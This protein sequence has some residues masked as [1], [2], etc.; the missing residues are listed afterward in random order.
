MGFGHPVYI[1]G[2]LSANHGGSKDNALAVVDAVA[3][4]GA[5]AVKF[6][7]YRPESMTVDVTNATTLVDGGPWSGRTL[8]DLYA[9]GM[10]PWEWIPDLAERAHS[11]GI[12]WL[13]TPFDPSAV[14]F[15]AEQGAPA[16]KI[17]S[18]ELTDLELIAC[19]AGV[20]VPLIISTGMATV[21]E[22]DAAVR[23]ATDTERGDLILL[24]CNSA[25][26]A[27]IAE[28]DL[29]TIRDMEE[30]WRVPI[31]LSDHSRGSTAAVVSVGLGACLIEKHVTLSRDNPTP[32]AAFSLEPEEFRQYVAAVRE[33]QSALGE[34]RYGPSPAERSSLSFRRSVVAVRTMS[35][36]QVIGPEDVAVLRPGHGLSPEHLPEV[37]GSIATTEIP[38]GAPVTRTMIR[39]PDS[40]R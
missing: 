19:A 39:R 25:Y 2:E 17:A 22:I 38:R 24:R 20:G 4:A 7:T 8:Y 32:D 28:M 3:E 33:A 5:D 14:E 11:R 40:A 30:R 12:Q 37:I 26:P 27:P 6:Q 15:L 9:E 21:E 10:T 23:V 34:T 35:K 36:D 16:M 1:V 31:G 13:S 18:F 29:R